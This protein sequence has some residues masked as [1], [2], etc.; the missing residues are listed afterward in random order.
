MALTLGAATVRWFNG[1]F[2]SGVK[3]SAGVS[4]GWGKVDG[5]EI[6]PSR[7]RARARRG[8]V[9][10]WMFL[11]LLLLMMRAGRKKKKN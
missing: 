6:A 7:A 5:A 8:V 2:K 4:A 3:I 10:S 1:L 11:V 9:G